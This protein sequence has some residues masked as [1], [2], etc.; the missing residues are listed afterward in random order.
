MIFLVCIIASE[1]QRTLIY[2][3]QVKS[4]LLD[5]YT[6]IKKFFVDLF[7]INISLDSLGSCIK[8]K[9]I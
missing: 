6:K 2:G 7:Q 3:E 8:N 4:N 5:N 9:L 1:S